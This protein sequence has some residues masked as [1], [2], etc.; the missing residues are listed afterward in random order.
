VH[1]GLTPLPEPAS[2]H[3]QGVNMGNYSKK[4]LNIANTVPPRW[5]LRSSK[6]WA[7]VGRQRYESRGVF[8]RGA[9]GLGG[10]QHSGDNQSLV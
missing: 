5:F 8:F 4:V 7:G 3:L 9:P 2:G 6:R 10:G 1:H